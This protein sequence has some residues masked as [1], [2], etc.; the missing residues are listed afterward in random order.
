MELFLVPADNC[1]TIGGVDPGDMR[2]ARVTT[3]HE[4]RGIVEAWTADPDTT[5]PTC[6]DTTS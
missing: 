3:M 1:D 2:L 4:A 5:F 6:E